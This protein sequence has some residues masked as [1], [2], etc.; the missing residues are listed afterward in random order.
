MVVDPELE[1]QQANVTPTPELPDK[2][3]GKSP[4]EIVEM[5]Q[6]LES[7]HGRRANEVGH[8]RKLTDELLGFARVGASKPANPEPPPKAVTA[9]DVLRDPA[10]TITNVAKRVADERASTTEARLASLEVSLMEERFEQRH[11]GFR[12]KMNDQK[13]LDWV[14]ASDYRK[15][16]AYAATQN[17]FGAADDLFSLH[18][19]YEKL[20]Q[21][22]P[23]STDAARA[24]GLAKSGGSSAS[25][26]IPKTQSDGKKIYSRAALIE[27]RIRNPEGFDAKFETE[28]KQAYAEG[29]V[30]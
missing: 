7:E 10:E 12:A 29:R 21:Q 28:Y 14:S 27:E 17:D 19:E 3:K 24:A 8:L 25:G 23:N 4:L 15:R 11:P 16:L 6:H 13:F 22:A 9:D 2:F 1:Q 20:G 18:E 5:Y 30:R 26:V